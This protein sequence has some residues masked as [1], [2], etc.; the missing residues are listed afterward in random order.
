[1]DGVKKIGTPSFPVIAAIREQDVEKLT[2]TY[3]YR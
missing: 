3:S 1:L 2:V